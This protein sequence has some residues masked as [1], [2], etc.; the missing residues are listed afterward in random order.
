M[1]DEAQR[2]WNRDQASKFMRQKRGN[3]SFDMS[4]PAFLVSVM[5]RHDGWCVKAQG[6]IITLTR[7]GEYIF[8]DKYAVYR[9]RLLRPIRPSEEP[10]EMLRLVGKPEREAA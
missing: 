8:T 3:A 2:A 10:D 7:G 4:E 6:T 9:D 1:F 5:D